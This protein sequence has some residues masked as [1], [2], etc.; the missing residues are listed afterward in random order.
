M[1]LVFLILLLLP[2]SQAKWFDYLM[3]TTTDLYCNVLTCCDDPNIHFKYHFL[4]REIKTLVFGQHLVSDVVLNAIKSHWLKENPQKALVLSFHG[5]TGCGKNYVAEI[6]ARNAFSGGLR[7]HQVKHIVATNDFPDVRK[8][9]EYRISLRDLIIS[10]VKKCPRALFIFDET[11]KLPAKLLDTIKPFI[12]YHPLISRFDFRKTIFIFLSNRG[13]SEI[14]NITLEN[15][16][17]GFPREQLTMNHFERRLSEHAYNADG[18]L[19]D[20]SIIFHHLID[21]YIPFLPLQKEHV[22]SCIKTYLQKRRH[23]NLKPN[24]IQKI[25]DSLA[26]FPKSSNAFSAFGCKRVVAKTDLELSKLGN[27]EL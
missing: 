8:I 15:Y 13:G 18:G 7:S 24:V 25:L 14:A 12:D 2:F 16:E 6:I 1:R 22:K 11:D 17:N 4:E 26:Y 20:S 3:N 5:P 21:H 9:N 23:D 27:D 10:T 19:K